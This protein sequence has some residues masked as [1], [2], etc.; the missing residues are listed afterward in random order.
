MRTKLVYVLVSDNEQSDYLEQCLLSCYSA[1]LHNAGAEIVLFVDHLTDD[2]LQGKRARRFSPWRK[3][4]RNFELRY[5]ASQFFIRL[6]VNLK[7]SC[8]FVP[9]S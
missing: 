4:S 5:C 1:R 7:F 8:K 6:W 9:Y 2:T 3:A